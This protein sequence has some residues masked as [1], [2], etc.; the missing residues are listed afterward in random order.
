MLKNRK[1][2][3]LSVF[4]LISVLSITI[5]FKIN[6]KKY[7]IKVGKATVAV[8][9][10]DKSVDKFPNKGLYDVIVDCNGGKG[11]WD[12]Q[13]WKLV[14]SEMT[15]KLYCNIK[16]TTSSKT[17][18]K[19]KVKSLVNN[20][21]VFNENGYRYEGK[22]VDNYVWFNNELWR[23]IG[24]FGEERHGLAGEEL[25]KI[26]RS[27]SLGSI[28]YDKSNKNAWETSSL[29][30]LL[31]GAY[32]NRENGNETAVDYC[33][34]YYAS[35]TNNTYSTQGDCDYMETGIGDAYQNM[36]KEVYWKIGSASTNGPAND[37]YT[38]ENASMTITTSK[39]GLMN[40]SDYAYSAQA[41]SCNRTIA[42]HYYPGIC[43]SDSWIVGQGTEW[44][45][46]PFSTRSDYVFTLY[47]DG[48]VNCT[49][50]AYRSY[51]YRPVLYLDS[52]VYTYA[53]DGTKTNPY[54]IG[55]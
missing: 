46:M 35:S 55:M 26:I 42:L 30:N 7:T 53:G 34:K 31:N 12:Y 39:I 24:V 13:N 25:V 1:I 41:E 17:N 44:T 10:D 5:Y 22:N 18:L 11:I 33:Y 38:A 3:I 20:G 14:V 40:A 48:R 27:D 6:N 4:V 2:I 8:L 51:A 50:D 16:F 49:S 32:L 45:I 9:L 15:E 54:I 36:I 52:S 29:K 23:I 43:A 19:D 47:Y 28:V 37:L 21:Q